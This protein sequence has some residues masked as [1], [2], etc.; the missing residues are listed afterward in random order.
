MLRILIILAICVLAGHYVAED[1]ARV[2]GVNNFDMAA[3][4]GGMHLAHEHCEDNFILPFLAE[5]PVG[6]VIADRVNALM[7][8]TSVFSIPPLLP[9]PNS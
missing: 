7:I 3:Q 8:G 5:M 6:S 2:T 1:L 9:P 4:G